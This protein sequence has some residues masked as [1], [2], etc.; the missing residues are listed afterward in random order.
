VSRRQEDVDDEGF[1][2]TSRYT[3][4][5]DRGWSLLDRGDFQQARNSAHQA[6]K[7][8]PGVPD[9]AML[10][11]AICLAENDPEGS[12][13]WYERAIEADAEYVEAQLAAAQILLY[14]LDEPQRAL[15]RAETAHELDEAT[16][17][18]HIEFGLLEVDALLMMNDV[19]GARERLANLA[20]LSVLEQLL[21]PESSEND[22]RQRLHEFIGEYYELESEELA[23]VVHRASQLALRVARLYLD[24]GGEDGA[25][26]ALPWL[27]LLLRGLRQDPEVWYLANEAAHL[28]GDPIRAAHAALQVLQLDAQTPLPEWAPTPSEIHVK[29]V[30][31]LIKCPDPQLRALAREPNFV[32]IVNDAPPYEMCLEG[33]DPRAR[34]VA[35][36]ARK[37]SEHESTTVLTGLAL[38]HRNLIRFSR[39]RASVDREIELSMFD[40]L[41]VFFGF[42]DA[43][44]ERLGLPASDLVVSHPGIRREL[45]PEDRRKLAP[46]EPIGETVSEPP[47]VAEAPA[48]P[49]QAKPHQAKPHQAKPHQ[50][51]P[52]LAKPRQAKPK[53][54]AAA[55]AHTKAHTKVGSKKSR[56]A[57]PVESKP[58]KAK[59]SKAKPKPAKVPKT[60]DKPPRKRP[61]GEPQDD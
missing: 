23:P 48:K 21:S 16:V 50:A 25:Q 7:L 18:D 9:G 61:A 37:I 17:A 53:K 11:A 5:L 47:A 55:K 27:D 2:E 34:A 36:A 42:D 20:E 33:V 31:L 49:H 46:P 29:V 41:A 8:R 38:Y 10:M 52:S 59:K 43:R 39:D 24:L 51:K 22:L 6:M 35:M 45:E 13:E 58:G 15:M 57:E 26:A 28:A 14:D 60:D 54:K 12:L 56:S 3:A 19:A 32:V 44:R 4:H 30:E 1:G 40:E